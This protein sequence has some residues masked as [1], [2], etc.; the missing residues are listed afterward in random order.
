[1]FL[2]LVYYRLKEELTRLISSHLEVANE[3]RTSYDIH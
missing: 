2:S 3:P 1:M